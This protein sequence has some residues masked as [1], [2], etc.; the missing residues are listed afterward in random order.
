LTPISDPTRG[1]NLFLGVRPCG[2][3]AISRDD[4]I[5]ALILGLTALIAGLAFLICVRP[6]LPYDEPSHYNVVQSYSRLNGMPTPGQ[7]GSSY[8]AYHPPLYY[9]SSGLFYRAVLSHLTPAAAL[10]GTRAITLLVFAPLVVLIYGLTLMVTGSRPAGWGAGL[11]VAFNPALLAIAASVQNDS[12]MF[13]LSTIAAYMCVA[14]LGGPTPT[15]KRA[16]GMGLIVGADVLTKTSALPVLAVVLVVLIAHR[17]RKGI[18]PAAWVVLTVAIVAGWWFVR[19]VRLYGD[20]TGSAAVAD[21]FGHGGR[22]RLTSV[23]DWSQTVRSLITYFTLPVE[24]WR[25]EVKATALERAVVVVALIWLAVGAI[26]LFR[27]RLRAGRLSAQRRFD[28]PV[29]TIAAFAGAGIMFWVVI[30]VRNYVVPPRVGMSGLAGVA[31]LV[32]VLN[33]RAAT[34]AFGRKTWTGRAAIFLIG[35][36]LLSLDVGM[37][38]AAHRLPPRP[39]DIRLKTGP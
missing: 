26:A 7:T 32:G 39:Y 20:W 5:A 38:V 28:L 31:V 24:Y 4:W 18:A 9:L 19:N 22:F 23:R 33:S 35:A 30:C 15:I 27:D 10:Y 34:V 11:F 29:I 1:S 14:W 25:N 37:L 2:R 13:L 12:L 21:L 17:G 36:T 8:E 6:G 3:I 16:V